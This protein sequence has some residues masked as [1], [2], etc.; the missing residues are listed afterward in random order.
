MNILHT[1]TRRALGKN[2]VRTWVT[3]IGIVLSMALLTAVIEGAYSG[4]CYTRGIM[5][6]DGGWYHA[7]YFD[8]DEAQMRETA[9]LKFID[10]R[11]VW[12]MVGWEVQ[13]ADA[14]R[15]PLFV[16][17][18]DDHV[19]DMLSLKLIEGRLPENE[20]EL[21][22]SS[23]FYDAYGA[24]RDE[25]A[26]DAFQVGNTVTM[27]L[28]RRIDGEGSVLSEREYAED[29]RIVDAKPYTYTIVGVYNGFN[30]ILGGEGYR[31][32]TRGFGTG[33]YNVFFTV[34]HPYFLRSIMGRQTLSQ[35]WGENTQLMR[36]YGSFSDMN[37]SA[38]LFGFAAILVILVMFGSISLIY[39]AFSISVAER[40]RQ[41]GILKSIGATKKQIRASVR[42]EALLLCAVGIPIGLIV[43]CVGIGVTL[44]AIKDTFI[45]LAP[46]IHTEMKLVLHP[47][48][49][50][51]AVLCCLVTVL[52]SASVP[53]KRAAR[54]QP[55]DAIRQSAD[56]KAKPREVRTSR[57]TEKLFGFEGA[58]GA[59]NFKRNKK[60]YR[61]TVLSLVMS[62]VL[63]IG[64]SSFCTYLT[65]MVRTLM[66]DNDADVVGTV[67]IAQVDAL[68]NEIKASEEVTRASYYFIYY[69][70]VFGMQT[71]SD[72]LSDSY[73]SAPHHRREGDREDVN[74]SVLYLDDASFRELCK[75]NHIDPERYFDPDCPY[76]LLKNEVTDVI[77]EANNRQKRYQY[78]VFR[79]DKLPASVVS[80]DVPEREGFY[81]DIS[82]DPETGKDFVRY[83]PSEYVEEQLRRANADNGYM[84]VLYSAM[85]ADTLTV[86]E[87]SVF[88]TFPFDAIIKGNNFNV[89]LRD[90][91]LIVYPFSKCTLANAEADQA[92]MMFE[93]DDHK[94]TYSKLH[95]AA[96]RDN[97]LYVNYVGDL[98]EERENSRLIVN[99]VNVFA[100]GFIILISLIAAANVF[101]TI[102]TAIMLR[103]REFAMLKSI[104]MGDRGMLRML[105]YE[106]LIY[107]LRA[108]LF[109]LPISALLTFAIFKVV[110]Q[111]LERSFY[112]PWT[113]V[114]I[115]VLSVFIVV[116]A[117]MLYA[118]SK[119]RKDNPVDALKN[120]NL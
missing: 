66:E 106:C 3:I 67:K 77:Q 33:S 49:L 114:L 2:R 86:D 119:I 31:A 40:T 71:D 25:T 39:N 112:M 50:L 76:G 72:N 90:R 89:V 13:D 41:F 91:A 64:A 111:E 99:V 60:G 81:K 84:V 56:V 113:S 69:G 75:E 82:Y 9:N 120:E 8:L 32:L 115:A 42:Y 16:E 24:N 37:L 11:A 87:A 18:I 109:G 29:A 48:A 23:R 30:T 98:A 118:R 97:M 28:G 70:G 52:I 12:Q 102:S 117:T 85:A 100:Y 58:M 54:L 20:H 10:E 74:V 105:N 35:N 55:I 47:L 108:L 19:A 79:T 53:A 26:L 95:E 43:G 51:A 83:Y 5:I 1:Y 34:N 59:K 38:V 22:V 65:D 92:Y 4:L 88:E 14:E 93:S 103:R 80:L 110:A 96:E 78:E 61:I 7:Y 27:T 57:L 63:F 46:N 21:I 116:F 68:F 17:A 36:L 107:G 62:I 104:G 44:W 45:K 94:A 15:M 101:N 6:E 73:W